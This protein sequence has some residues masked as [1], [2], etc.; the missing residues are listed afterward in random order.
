[1]LWLRHVL[2]QMKDMPE[3]AEK[4][5]SVSLTVLA[6]RLDERAKLIEPRVEQLE[7]VLLGLRSV[8]LLPKGPGRRGDA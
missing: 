8:P 5:G 4:Q 7:L 6:G 3:A 2:E 1:V